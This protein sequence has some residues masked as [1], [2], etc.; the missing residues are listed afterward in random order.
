MGHDLKNII[1]G[2]SNLNI[3]I[4]ATIGD[5]FSIEGILKKLKRF[6]NFGLDY[7]KFGINTDKIFELKKLFFDI[8]KLKLKTKLVLVIFVDKK[9]ILKI[10]EQNLNIFCQ[11]NIK[12]FILDTYKKNN[13]NLTSFCK[14]SQIKIFIEKCSIQK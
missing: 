3:K 12:F 2:C 13:Q 6:D 11:S 8:G 7:I 10:I 5:V 4:S 9:K 1:K 14:I